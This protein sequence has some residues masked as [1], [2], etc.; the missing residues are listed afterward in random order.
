MT[1]CCRRAANM[2]RDTPLRC[3]VA[4]LLLLS[5]FNC[6]NAVEAASKVDDSKGPVFLKEPTNRIDFSNSTGAVVECSAT[7][8]PPPE[9]IWI[10]SDGTAVGEVPGLRQILPNGNLVFPPFRAEDYRQDV[11]AQV[12]AC[13]AKN[14][15]GS[16]I[17]RDVNVRAVINQHYQPEI[18]TEYVIR[19]NSAILKCSIPSFVSDFVRVESWID[20][21]GTEMTPS[22]DYDGKYMVLPSGELHIREVGPEDGYKSYQCRTKHRLTG[23]TRLSA[24]KGRLVITEPVGSVAPRLTSGDESRKLLVKYRA[25]VTMLCPAQSFPVPVFRWYKYIEGTTRKQAVVLDDRVKQVSGTLIIKDAVVD[26]SGKFLCVVNNSV[27]GESVETV[28][29]VTA[30]LA[31]KIEPRTQ[32]VDFGR[33][34]VFTCK[35][36]GNP[37]K[38]V[39]WMKDGKSLGHSDAVLRIESV[40]KEDRGMYQCFIRNDQES[41]QASAELKLGGRFDPPVIREAF[42]EETRHPG[43]SV[44]L[45]CI[46]GGNPTPEISWELDGKKITNS[47]RYQVGQYVTVNGDV[48]SHLNI[49]SIHSNDGGLYK[50]SASSKV[51]VAEHSAK[52]NVYGLPYVRTMEKKSIVAGETLIVTCP[53]AGYPIESIVWERD[54]R[55]LPINRKQKVFPNG[56]LII[57]NVERNSDQATYTCVAKNSEGY[58]ARGT[59]EVAVMVPPKIFPFSFG[60]EPMNF[61]D[62]VSIQC[63]VPSGD[64][65]IGIRWYFNG[66]DIDDSSVSIT[67]IGKRSKVLTIDSVTGR[68]AGN[69]SCEASNKADVVQFSAELNINVPPRWILEPTDKA[70]AQG[71]NAK[72]ECKA[73]GFPKPQVSWKKAIGD[74]PGEY[75][76]LRSNDSSIRVEEG[77]LFI[78][79]IQKSNEG[80]YLCEAI[81]GIGSGLSAVILISVQAPPEFTEKLRNQTARRGEPTVLQCEAKGE[82]PI[83][84]LWNMNNIRLDPK[85]DNRYTIR[86]EIRPDGVMS[87]LSIKRTER[88]DSALFTCMATNAFGSDDASINMIIQEA[89]EMPY[90]LKVLDKSGR[91]VQLSW[92]KPYDGNSPLKRYII[93]FKRSRGTWDNDV[94]RVIVPGHTNEAQVQKLSPATTYN[95]RIVAENEIGVS[96]SSEVVTII[97]AE[98]APTG[99]PQAIK[100][101]PINQTTLRV[102]WKAPPRAE[103]NG[104]ILGYYVGFKQTSHNSSYIYETVNYSLEGGEG[105]EH[106]LEI[107]NLKT[108][109]QYTIVI[110]AFNKVGAGPMSEEEKQYTAEGTPDQPPSDTMCTTLTSQTIRVSWVSPP[111]ESANGVI[112]GYK[113]V[114][115]PSDLWND[116]KNKDYKKTASSDTVLHGLKKYTNYTMQ[117]LATTSGGDGVRSAPIHCQTEQDVPESPTAMK[118]LVM[119]E[120]SILV[121]WQPPSQPN[122]VILQYTVYIKSGEQEPK[123]HKVPSYQTSYEASGLEKNQQYEFWVTASTNIG[124]GQQS[125]TVSAMPSDKVPAK[126]ASFDDTFTATFKEDAKL[127]CLA[128]GSPTPDITWKI[129]GQEFVPNERIRQLPEGSLFIKDVIRQDAGDYTCTAENSIAKDSI[130]HRLIILAPPQS[131]QLTLTA[132]TTD[133]LAVKLKPHESDSAPMQGYTLHYKPEFGDWETIDVALEAPKYTIENLFCGLRYQVYATAYNSIGAGE[134]SDI[135]NTRTKGSKPLLPEKSRFIEVSSNSITLHLPAW[136]DGG[137]RMSHFV[138]EHKKKDQV[139]WNQISNNVKPGGNFVVL[140]L[141]PATWYNL[142]VTAHNNA[143]F[144]VAEYEF[145]TL[146]IT[147]GTIAPTRDVPELTAEDTIRIILSNLNLVVPVV[148]ALLVIII[149]IIVICVLRNK[150]N[151]NKDDV[152]YNQSMGPAGAATLDKRRPDIRDELGYIAP[153]NRKLPPVPGSNYNTCDRVK[154]GTVI[155]HNH[156]NKSNHSTWDPRRPLYEELKNV[157]PPLPRRCNHPPACYGMEDEICPYATFHL[158]G[159]REEMDPTKAMNFQTFPHQNGMGGPGHMGTM[160]SNMAMQMPNHVHSR[161]GSQSMPRQNRY[162]RKNSQGGQSSIYT[163]A[164]E[165][166]DPANCAEEDQYRRYTRINSQGGSMYCGPG[167]EYDDPANCAPEEDQYGSQYGGNYGTPYDHY[168]SRGSVGRR[169]AGSP[170]PPPPP[171]RNHDT[172]NS[173][174]NDSKE[175]NEISEAECDRDNGPRGNYSEPAEATAKSTDA[176]NTEETEKLLKSRNEIKP[177]YAKQAAAAPASAGLT[178]YDTMAV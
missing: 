119:S 135:L 110:Q 60:D 27:G 122:G 134:P 74:T 53:V 178:A 170:E 77:S 98:E 157:G 161:S 118:A 63:N 105:K 75:K 44:F 68:H 93:E 101:E 142:R 30:P 70:F 31:A 51:G 23:E 108:Y 12:Y 138:V 4:L 124:E 167:P 164:P 163:P 175:S 165:Y 71:S 109:T 174:F 39:S 19:G 160:G 148:A 153:P 37:I 146:T 166:D 159:F 171:P 18:L 3:G 56:T 34:A 49:S 72:V 106:S 88:S 36:S 73:D 9:M 91:T 66:K 137:C 141:E 58:T 90:A 26:D 28:L 149:A 154:R 104:D 102:S 54:N 10:R 173:S 21:E 123:N 132:T 20:E 94:D 89:P 111:L 107:N 103:W 5:G 67:N 158:L 78:N 130:T 81:N 24:T 99:K 152:V 69:Y 59:L 11:H 117:V 125:K 144:T 145:A 87:S 151:N 64:L 45:K 131:P 52:L 61:G 57:E 133:S 16:I 95:I 116:D 121:S 128:V 127:P 79:N 13:M 169:S 25:N 172:S 168:G 2:F 147:G 7:G 38:T 35:F 112:K 126:I 139:D 76:D 43:P 83:G 176:L 48:V 92:A 143:G 177:K 22:E 50:C 162:A 100:I 17:S 47:E 46:A 84:I 156:N 120:G 62:S 113:V 40:K 42:P 8:N 55:Q 140:D 80:Y 33:P 150:G 82:K 114:Y 32:T 115:A 65:P 29:T 41:A 6:F 155:S 136:K 86:E 129:K 14:Q 96:D 97:T 1:V 15:F 85:S